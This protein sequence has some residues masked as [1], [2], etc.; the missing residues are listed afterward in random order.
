[1][2]TETE[3]LTGLRARTNVF[4]V[5]KPF[6]ALGV[7]GTAK[8]QSEIDAHI[9]QQD[10]VNIAMGE[11]LERAV[12]VGFVDAD[13][14]PQKTKLQYSIGEDGVIFNPSTLPPTHD[15]HTA[16]TAWLATNYKVVGKGGSS[17]I[18][19][20]WITAVDEQRGYAHVQ[21]LMSVNSVEYKMQRYL[22]M[23]AVDVWHFG[24]D[25]TAING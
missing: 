10:K 19:R 7:L 24:P 17:T 13:D 9:A 2:A 14:N 23:L 15:F 22:L 1:M 4:R 18:H 5:G 3:F 12:W 16:A 8:N 21:V 20:A 11:P 25:V 6:H